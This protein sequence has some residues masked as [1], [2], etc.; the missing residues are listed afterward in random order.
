[1]DKLIR[2]GWVFMSSLFIWFSVVM[3][4]VIGG[5]SGLLNFAEVMAILGTLAL[6]L[7]I[8]FIEMSGNAPVSE[9]EKAKRQSSSPDAR[10]A[11]LVQLLGEEE[12]QAVKQKLIDD[13]GADGEAVS[14]ADLLKDQPDRSR[15]QRS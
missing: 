7:T 5:D 15:Q 3:V 6:W 1:M 2:F 11:L 9:Q 10:L 12:R 4:K 13:L 14:L 8:G